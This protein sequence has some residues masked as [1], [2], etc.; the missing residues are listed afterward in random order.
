MVVFP[1]PFG[2][3]QPDDLALLEV[4]VDVVDHLAALVGLPEVLRVEHA[5]AAADACMGGAGRLIAHQGAF[6][7]VAEQ[8]DQL[9]A[10]VGDIEPHVQRERD[11]RLAPESADGQGHDVELRQPRE[12]GV[13]EM[14]AHVVA[15]ELRGVRGPRPHG[16]LLQGQVVLAVGDRQLRERGAAERVRDARQRGDPERERRAAHGEQLCQAGREWPGGHRVPFGFVAGAFP[17]LTLSLAVLSGGGAGGMGSS[18]TPSACPVTI[19][20]SILSPFIATSITAPR[21]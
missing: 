8:P 17:P 11:G 7:G 13:A 16:F 14:G 6:G 20:R 4:D 12:H 19:T 10:V 15:G 2:T 18:C 9:V 5:G 21:E 1:A 3:E